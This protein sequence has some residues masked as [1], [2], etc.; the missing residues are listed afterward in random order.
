[1][2]EN[3]IVVRSFE[4]ARMVIQCC[5]MLR[6]NREYDLASQLLRSGTSIGANVQEAQAALTKKEFVSKMSIAAKEARESGYWIRLLSSEGL[7]DNAPARD[8]L[9]SEIIALQKI[10]TSIIKT[11]Q[12]KG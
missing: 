6:Q 4:Y 11:A 5:R 10:L 9:H 7:L 2:K 8:K 12:E 3:E 1:M